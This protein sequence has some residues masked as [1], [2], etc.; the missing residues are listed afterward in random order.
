MPETPQRFH[1]CAYETSAGRCP[2][3]GWHVRGPKGVHA[4]YYCLAHA[5]WHDKNVGTRGMPPAQTAISF[6][7]PSVQSSFFDEQEKPDAQE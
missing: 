5:T 4:I 1:R 2:R 6:P 3:E 7:S